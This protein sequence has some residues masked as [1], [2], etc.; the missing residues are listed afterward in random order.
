MSI[1][2]RP[3]TLRDTLELKYNIVAVYRDILNHADLPYT[4]D[5]LK[6]PW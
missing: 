2:V 6:K 5:E 4:F 3:I 1:I